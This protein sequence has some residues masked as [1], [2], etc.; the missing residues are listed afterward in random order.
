M[1]ETNDKEALDLRENLANSKDL[2]DF[3]VDL[4]DDKES[5][6]C[7]VDLNNEN[8]LLGFK[9]DSNNDKDSLNFNMDS[10]DIKIKEQLDILFKDYR[11]PDPNI[12]DKFYIKNIYDSIETKK[13]YNI[14]KQIEYFGYFVFLIALITGLFYNSKPF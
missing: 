4:N 5:T 14:E 6:N 2:L 1:H 3:K 10:I 13:I 9:I 7:K 8:E 12:T 11:T